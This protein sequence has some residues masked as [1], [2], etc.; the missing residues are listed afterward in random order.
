ML[1][2]VPIQMA[3]DT[4]GPRQSPA[5]ALRAWRYSFSTVLRALLQGYVGLSA[6]W[7]ALAHVEENRSSSNA[8]N[9]NDNDSN[10]AR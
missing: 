3:G 10:D 2:P 8:Q 5:E 6:F 9:H 1:L 7:R 4:G